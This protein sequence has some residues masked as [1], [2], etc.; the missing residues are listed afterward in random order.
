MPLHLSAARS[1]FRFHA[2]GFRMPGPPPLLSLPRFPS[3]GE[4]QAKAAF[5][6]G[7]RSAPRR[8][9]MAVC[10]DRNVVI[11]AFR[12]PASS[13]FMA[14]LFR[15]FAAAA[16]VSVF[17]CVI[18]SIMSRMGPL[19]STAASRVEALAER[20][21]LS[22]CSAFFLFQRIPA[23]AVLYDLPADLSGGAVQ[24]IFQHVGRPQLLGQ[25]FQLPHDPG[26]FF[27]GV[28]LQN[29]LIAHD[30][31]ASSSTA[32]TPASS[33]QVFTLYALPSSVSMAPW[34]GRGPKSAF[35]T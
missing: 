32:S 16:A 2:A 19:A 3:C 33:V 12:P 20:I 8:C 28:D 17:G 9:T 1:A 7:R 22:D 27:V 4:R 30:L 10:P 15:T 23:F 26:Q 24:G 35:A 34:A 29:A 18:K 31:T 11:N 21:L 25:R 6:T 5:L 13:G 14:P